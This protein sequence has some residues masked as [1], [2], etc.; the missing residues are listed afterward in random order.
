MAQLN[1]EPQG[2]FINGVQ[3]PVKDGSFTASLGGF[4]RTSQTGSGRRL[5][6]TRQVAVGTCGFTVTYP[7]GTKIRD[8]YDV[9][10]A[11]IRVVFDRGDEWLM[12]GADLAEPV[13]FSAGEG[14]LTLAYEGDP[15]EQTK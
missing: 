12:T 15:W 8:T 7:R 1:S 3:V 5:G 14:D 4:T 9:E 2:V 6:S 11:Q 10:D 13:D